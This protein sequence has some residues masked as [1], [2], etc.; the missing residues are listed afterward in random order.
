METPLSVLLESLHFYF[1]LSY[2]FLLSLESKNQLWWKR[3]YK[4]CTIIGG[5]GEGGE[6][7]GEGAR[8]SLWLGLVSS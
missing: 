1:T 8:V 6:G 4:K 7:R 3:G 2:V 5:V